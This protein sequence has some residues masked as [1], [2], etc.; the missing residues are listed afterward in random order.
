MSQY[1]RVGHFLSCL[2]HGFINLMI[3]NGNIIE[4]KLIADLTK[5]FPVPLLHLIQVFSSF[6]Y[7]LKSNYVCW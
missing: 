2:F 6:C 4:S 7:G 5:C 1:T 3:P